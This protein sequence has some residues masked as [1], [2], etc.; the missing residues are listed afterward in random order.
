VPVSTIVPGDVIALSAGNLIPADGLVIEAEDFLVNEA[1]L[2]GESFPV[3]K[4][5]GTI[6]QETPLARRANAV[7]L[8]ASVQSGTAK[9]LAVETG[10]RTAFGA[11]VARIQARPPETE[12]GRGIRQF[13]YL[14]IRVMSSS[15]CSC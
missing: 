15:F 10:R 8:G 2:T 14:L 3:E 4:R 12:F 6:P 1:S 11:I 5:P 7:Y 13:G 9:V